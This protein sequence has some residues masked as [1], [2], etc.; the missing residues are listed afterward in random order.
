MIKFSTIVY[1]TA[2]SL[3]VETF[4]CHAQALHL[5]AC[6]SLASSLPSSK[7][8]F[9]NAS[10]FALSNSYWSA[11]Q[12]EV[13]PSC[14]AYPESTEDVSVIV[15]L[16]ASLSAPFTV[17]SGGHTAFLGSNIQDGV[18]IDLVR[19]GQVT[20][21]PDQQTTSIGPGVRWTQVAETLD[22]LGLVV[23]GGRIGDV[24]V[25]G[26]TLGG[27]ISYFSGRY[28]WACD[29]V[30][31]FEV[32]LASGEVVE[33]SPEQNTDL[34]WALRGGGGSSFGIV[35]RFD[36]AT[37]PQGNLWTHQ[38]YHPPSVRSEL[39]SAYVDLAVN[40]LVSDPDAHTFMV[41]AADN[42][43][44]GG[45]IVANYM[46]HAVPPAT[47]TT[48]PDA[49]PPVFAKSNAVS[50][51]LF[52]STMAA[53]IS[54]HFAGLVDPAGSRKTWSNMAVRLVEE[55]SEQLLEELYGIWQTHHARV[56]AL[57]A[58]AGDPAAWGSFILQP[59]PTNVIEAM[60]KKGGNALGLLPEDGPLTLVQLMSSWSVPDIDEGILASE[61]AVIADMRAL[62]A[63]KGVSSD[64]VYMNYAGKGQDVLGGYGRANLERLAEVAQAYDPDGIMK[65]LWKGYFQV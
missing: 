33:A 63:D 37:Y 58:A 64:F 32:V 41:F 50:N 9:P 13:A 49:V 24:G 1:Y 16:L 6:A 3:L 26:L 38:N 20:V 10:S 44:V 31:A 34:Y 56:R 8:S 39:F 7:V 47:T 51:V 2:G 65:K 29:N 61:A 4:S 18:T 19:L 54:T 11:R 36:L 59:I 35:S 12:S 23:I 46:Y 52:S 25:S 27:G 21:S 15:K 28:G 62:A 57:G 45:E 5:D 43:S 30:R 17:K 22:P 40:G 42:P 60:Q 55:G 53:N 14:F 48:T